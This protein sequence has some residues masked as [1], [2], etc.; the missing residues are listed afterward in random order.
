MILREA[1]SGDR[2]AILDIASRTW[3]GWD[4]VP[5]F[6]DKWLS[7]GGLYVAEVEGRL[8]GLTKTT[9]LSHGELWFEG[10]RVRED[11]RGRG[12]GLEIARKQ[13]E[14]ALLNNPNSI[15]LST[16]DVNEA[17]R[18]IIHAIGFREY[19]HFRYYEN[20]KPVEIATI[21]PEGIKKVESDKDSEK[22]WKIILR[23]QE[24][25]ASRGLLPHTWKFSEFTRELFDK[26]V[27]DGDVYTSKDAEGVLVLLDNRYNPGSLEITFLEGSAKALE[28]LSQF[29]SKKVLSFSPGFFVTG[30]AASDRKCG[31]LEGAGMRKHEEIEKVYVFDYPLS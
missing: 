6:L 7:E 21:M 18:K 28:E 1:Q 11:E 3:E 17:S 4:Y 26:L 2:A 25:K 15:R 14:L 22:T 10:I 13:L 5:L 9:E 31:I 29:A 16:A 12:V 20:E 23:S 8:I 30:F 27:K 19:V 24:Y